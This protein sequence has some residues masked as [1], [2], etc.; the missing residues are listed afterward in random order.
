MCVLCCETT[1]FA[2]LI[3]PLSAPFRCPAPGASPLFTPRGVNS[4]SLRQD[5]P[6]SDVE[7]WF[8]QVVVAVE[9]AGNEASADRSQHAARLEKI[10]CAVLSSLQAGELL[11]SHARRVKGA[12]QAGR[13][14]PHCC[15]LA[16]ALLQMSIPTS[17]LPPL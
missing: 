3:C 15:V 8:R 1:I 5:M 11:A 14:L 4:C 12:V 13:P 9:C 10:Y 7:H 17:H 2:G 16:I 6:M